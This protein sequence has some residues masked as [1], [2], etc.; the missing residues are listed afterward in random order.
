MQQLSEKFCNQVYGSKSGRRKG[1][2][3]K[4]LEKFCK[5]EERLVTDSRNN[6]LQRKG[7]KS[8]SES[9]NFNRKK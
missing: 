5:G 8:K 2:L 1:K 4:R 9:E 7:L 3:A 6:G